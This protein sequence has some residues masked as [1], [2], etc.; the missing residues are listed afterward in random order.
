MAEI[1]QE[2]VDRTEIGA[3]REAALEKKKGAG[4]LRLQVKYNAVHAYEVL[5]CELKCVSRR[6]NETAN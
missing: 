6:K 5:G 2:D 1:E 4:G 3:A